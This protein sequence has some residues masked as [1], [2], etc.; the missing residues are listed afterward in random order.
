MN[1]FEINS[2]IKIFKTMEL[3]ESGL[4]IMPK[5]GNL[6]TGGFYLWNPFDYLFV[7]STTPNLNTTRTNP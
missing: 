1:I 3:L 2:I 5:Y 4:S 7:V 6:G